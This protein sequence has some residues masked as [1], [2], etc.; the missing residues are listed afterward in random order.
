VEPTYKLRAMWHVLQL[1]NNNLADDGNSSLLNLYQTLKKPSSSPPHE[2]QLEA[3]ERLRKEGIVAFSDDQVTDDTLWGSDGPEIQVTNY[4]LSIKDKNQ[5]KALYQKHAKWSKDQKAQEPVVITYDPITG[6]GSV[7]SKDELALR[8][9][10][11]NIFDLLYANKNAWVPREAVL[12]AARFNFRQGA[13]STYATQC[14]TTYINNLRKA[15]GLTKYQ[16]LQANGHAMLKV[17]S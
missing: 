13:N 8:G 14:F 1:I 3:L 4:P 12:K 2:Y 9:I 7:N 5:L 15:T 17:R 16:I 11:K 10:N 6:M